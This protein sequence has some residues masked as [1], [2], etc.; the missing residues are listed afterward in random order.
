MRDFGGNL[1]PHGWFAA[2]Y[3]SLLRDML[4]REEGSQLHLLSVVSPEWLNEG[5]TIAVRRAPTAFGMV[6]Y[7]LTADRTGGTMTFTNSFS[8]SPDSII[9]HL[10]WFLSVGEI[11]ADGKKIPVY[12]RTVNLPVN[13][14]S[15]Y[16]SWH[17]NTNSDLMSYDR[18]VKDY[19]AEY[20]RRWKDF[21]EK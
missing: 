6:N 2:K 21:I 12:G 10:P 19:K 14:R 5:D 15:V 11:T 3:R 20:A 13:V 8:N 1:S 17:R 9:L 16:I 4:V 7:V 18:A